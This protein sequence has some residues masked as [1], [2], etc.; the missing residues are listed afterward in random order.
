MLDEL[1]T[2]RSSFRQGRRIQLA[3]RQVWTFPLPSREWIGIAWPPTEDY[4]AHI[5]SMIEA[6]DD[7]ETRRAEL[8]FAIFLLAQNYDLSPVDYQQL[9]DFGP[10]SAEAIHWQFAFHELAHEH[11]LYFSVAG[12][13]SLATQLT[14]ASQRK[15]S[16]PLNWLERTCYFAGDSLAL[17]VGEILSQSGDAER[18]EHRSAQPFPEFVLIEST[19]SQLV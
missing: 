2:R 7:S 13:F 11:L 6:E 10:D 1:Q 18:P 4:T 19:R 17:E 9:L 14:S 5:Q 8:A 12:V 15:F 3:D 16:R